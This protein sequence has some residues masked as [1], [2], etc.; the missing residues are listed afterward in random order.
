VNTVLSELLD[1]RAVLSSQW[2]SGRRGAALPLVVA[3][4]ARGFE[5]ATALADAPRRVGD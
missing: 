1:A 3:L 5:A 4:H 2:E